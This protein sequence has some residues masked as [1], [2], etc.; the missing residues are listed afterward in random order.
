ML[1]RSKE[2]KVGTEAL[3][4]MADTGFDQPLDYPNALPLQ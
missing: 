3:C 2:D 1:A 4:I